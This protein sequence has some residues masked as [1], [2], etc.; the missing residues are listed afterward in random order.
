MITSFFGHA[1][2]AVAYKMVV[3]NREQKCMNGTN[4]G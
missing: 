2:A 4:L 3:G 1:G